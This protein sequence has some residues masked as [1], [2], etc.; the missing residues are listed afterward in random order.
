MHVNKIP[1]GKTSVSP[2]I[3]NMIS[4]ILKIMPKRHTGPCLPAKW[5]KYKVRNY[6]FKAFKIPKSERSMQ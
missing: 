5:K 6:V 3:P 4:L 1:S 2:K